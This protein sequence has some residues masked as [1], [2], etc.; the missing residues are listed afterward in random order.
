[1][2]AYKCLR[3]GAV[4]PFS[5]FRWPQ[6]TPDAP[7][8]WVDSQPS[9]CASGIHACTPE[10]LPYW[11]NWELW[12]VELAGEIVEGETKVVASRGR[13]LTRVDVWGAELQDAFGRACSE[14]VLA[15]RGGGD[16]LAGYRRD[17][18]SFIEGGE[19]PAMMALLAARA[20]EAEAGDEARRAER[21]W[22]AQW[23]AEHLPALAG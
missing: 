10:Q 4:G 12:Q 18:R 1:V 13:L 8:P 15:R 11:L 6:P 3:K 19:P 2:I 23:L 17:A 16:D 22:Q 21:R 9:R 5:G 7:G 20:A 14:R